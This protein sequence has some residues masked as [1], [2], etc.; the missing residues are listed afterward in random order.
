MLPLFTTPPNILL[1]PP[2][3]K[4]HL[5]PHR[6]KPPHALTPL[7]L[8]PFP[9]VTP[10]ALGTWSWGNRLLY[11]YSPSNDKALQATFETA[12]TRGINLF[13]TA[14]SYGT[15][16][17]NA[18]AE[19]L[20]G[21][22]LS[23]SNNPPVL[24]AS[25][26]A[27]YPWRLSRSSIRDAAARSADRLGRPIDLG[28]IHWSASR[29]APWQER[30]LWD[31]VADARED[32]FLREVGV[33]N[34]GPRL[35]QSVERY[36]REERG[37]KLASVQ[38]QLSLLYR[39]PVAPGGLVE[40]AR[41]LGVGVMGYSPLCLG[42]LSGKYG[43][44]GMEMPGGPRGVLFRRL[45]DGGGTKLVCKL[46]EVGERRGLTPAQVA[47]A[48]CVAQGVVVIGGARTP[49]HVEEG[50]VACDVTLSKEEC[51]QLEAVAARG[52][53]MIANSFQ[54]D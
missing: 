30:A 37:V 44:D 51:F 53:Q 9:T 24:I 25:K 2:S 29:Y 39:D 32:G 13:D 26:F 28:Q 17:L 20:L 34:F 18:R 12:L 43:D 48:W 11:N 46:R 5:S 38:T 31:G 3:P 4:H 19:L 1:F 54:T 22:F 27:S 7:P 52:R 6:R 15:F 42:L 49:R 35:L 45:L 14:D 8:G 41:R 47:I 10:L 16:S 33:S 21:R 36:L 23:Q 40:T 50:L